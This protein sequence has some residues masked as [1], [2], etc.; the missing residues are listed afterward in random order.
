M[1]LAERLNR[2]DIAAGALAAL[3]LVHSSDGEPQRVDSVVSQSLQRAGEQP[4]AAVT[5]G[6]AIQSF[7]FYWLGRFDAALAS[8]RHAV[9]IARGMNDTQF[10]SY[11][12]PHAGLALAA[13]GAYADAERVFREAQQYCREYEIWPNLARAIAI[14]AGYHLDV[15]DFSGHEAIAEEARE[16]A[17]SANLLNP[18]VSASL[19]LLFNYVRRGD[20]SRA[21]RILADVAETVELAAGAHGWLWRLRLLEAR[22]ELAL[23]RGDWEASE[24]LA[25]RAI[26]EC[27]LRGRVKYEAFARE[28]R[29]RALAA[30]G[31]RHEAIVEARN[32]VALVR[33]LAAPA[34]FLRA[35]AT[36]LSLEGDDLLLTEARAAGKQIAVA[37]PSDELR[38]QFE[39][40]DLVRFLNL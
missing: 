39:A 3:A 1:N 8:A 12:L 9:E 25:E 37:L 24:R 17:R 31:R 6:V 14:S 16:L 33:P 30:L 7:N 18:L 28:T 29:A 21:E 23:T 35:A 36:Q 2:N 34:Q 10:I 38:R 27:R 20:V 15:F 5:F 22:A 11:S 19:D 32:G 4:I 13:Q 26:V 40:A